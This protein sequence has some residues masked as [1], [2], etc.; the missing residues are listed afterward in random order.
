MQTMERGNNH[1]Y[2]LLA[3][4]L[5][6]TLFHPLGRV[7]DVNRAAVERARAAGIQVVVAT[8]RSHIESIDYLDGLFPEGPMVTAGG[9]LTVEVESGRTLERRAM[10]TGLVREVVE[11]LQREAEHDVLVLKDAHATGTEY[12]VVGEGKLDASTRWWF[13]NIPVRT[14]WVKDLKD[15]PW[16]HETVRIGVV[17]RTSRIGPLGRGV[18]ERFGERAMI[19]YFGAA[20]DSGGTLHD[21]KGEKVHLLEVFAPETT[22]WTAIRALAAKRGIPAG[23]I[24]AIGDEA[25]DLAMIRGAGLGIAMGNA[26]AAVKQAA[27]QETGTNLEDGVA[28]AIEKILSGKW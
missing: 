16:P 9:A 20:T 21:E 15:D 1:R 14:H 6:G 18:V 8:G 13:E 26:A 11:H 25:N 4:D 28:M 12:V 27:N 2:D 7:S 17:T 22:K 10:N 19:H 24:A 5:D 3:L 23:R